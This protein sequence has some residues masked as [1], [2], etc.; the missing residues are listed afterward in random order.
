MGIAT[1]MKNL[2]QD[3]ASSHEDRLKRVGEIKEEAK[4][5]RE[6]AQGLVKGF[7]NLRRE[8]GVKMRKELAQGVTNRRSEVSGILADADQAIRGFRSHR[9]GMGSELRRELARSRATSKSEVGKLLKNAQGL[10]S[11]FQGSRKKTG[12]ELRKNLARTRAD[13]ESQVSD[14]RT[15]FREAQSEVR[16]ELREAKAAWQGLAATRVKMASKVKPSVA[17][18]EAVEV[19]VAEEEAP[20]LETKLLVAVNEHPNGITL[21]EVANS[22]GVVPIV[23]GRAARSLLENGKIRKE[24]KVYFPITG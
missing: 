4:Q 2:T 5:V 17:E 10:I 1:E 6:E 22:L 24:D 9:K 15:D 14:M 12:N 21:S 3:I 7:Q 20:D 13:R 16:G 23:L 19:A 8:E 11:D 18:E